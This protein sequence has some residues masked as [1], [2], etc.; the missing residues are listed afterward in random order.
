[1]GPSVVCGPLSLSVVMKRVEATN[2]RPLKDSH[3]II[4]LMECVKTKLTMKYKLK[5]L[6]RSRSGYKG[7]L[8]N[9]CNL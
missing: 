7:C 6:I 8:F 9:D 3:V 2:C 1:M 5:A 4:H